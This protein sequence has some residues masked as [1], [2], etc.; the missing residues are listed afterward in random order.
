MELCKIF[1]FN[2]I[3]VIILLII[4]LKEIERQ[5]VS[6]LRQHCRQFVYWGKREGSE[7]L[8]MF[9]RPGKIAIA[10]QGCIQTLPLPLLTLFHPKTFPPKL[11]TCLLSLLYSTTLPFLFLYLSIKHPLSHFQYLYK[12]NY[13]KIL[14]KS[15]TYSNKTLICNYDY[16]HFWIKIVKKQCKRFV[17]P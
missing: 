13:L 10:K 4:S 2:Y 16:Y 17:L 7:P 9:V 12:L 1:R 11:W 14:H 6:K 15:T 3:F 8:F 5:G